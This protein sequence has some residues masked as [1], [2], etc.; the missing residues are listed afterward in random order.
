MKNRKALCT[1]CGNKLNFNYYWHI[2]ICKKCRI[3]IMAEDNLHKLILTDKELK[4]AK[5]RL[6]DK[7]ETKNN[8]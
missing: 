4:I 5:I 3:K 6:E 2:P 1:R 8:K 7:N